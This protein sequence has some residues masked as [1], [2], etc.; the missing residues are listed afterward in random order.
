MLQQLTRKSKFKTKR[1]S[2][3]FSFCSFLWKNANVTTERHFGFLVLIYFYICWFCHIFVL[4]LFL[5]HFTKKKHTHTQPSHTQHQNIK[6]TC[7]NYKLQTAQNNQQQQHTWHQELSVQFGNKNNS[8][9]NFF[10]FFCDIDNYF[11]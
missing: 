3:F 5:F 9:C 10:Y 1:L 11:T 4:C 7:S 8:K 2:S 6:T